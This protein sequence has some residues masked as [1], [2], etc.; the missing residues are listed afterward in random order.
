MAER[1]YAH[2]KSW[3]QTENGRL[4]ERSNER[5]AGYELLNTHLVAL[6]ARGKPM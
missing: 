3:S 5:Q 4:N 1:K 2:Q 6:F